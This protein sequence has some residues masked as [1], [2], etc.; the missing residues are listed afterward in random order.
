MRTAKIIAETIAKRAIILPMSVLGN[1]RVGVGARL[2]KQGGR[3]TH[4]GLI[5]LLGMYAVSG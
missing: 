4:L 1:M 2:A 5:L 3:H